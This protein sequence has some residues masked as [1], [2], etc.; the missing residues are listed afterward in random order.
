MLTTTLSEKGNEGLKKEV[1]VSV[2]TG[3]RSWGSTAEGGRIVKKDGASLSP[4]PSQELWN[5]SPNGFEWGYA[6]S[7]SAQLA[8]ALLYD[9]L[10]DKYL[11]LY[12]HQGFKRQVSRF[13]DS[14]EI[15]SEDISAW[16]QGMRVSSGWAEAQKIVSGWIQ[17]QEES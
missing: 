15:T 8:L 10:G 1:K 14:W 7:G 11:A 4:E 13:A 16:V 17:R 5:H 3:D 12:Y 6:K 2:Y 9:V